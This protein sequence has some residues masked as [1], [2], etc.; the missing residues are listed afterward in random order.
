MIDNV[1]RAY[2]GF[3]VVAE[4][5]SATLASLPFTGESTRSFSSI[6]WAVCRLLHAL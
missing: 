3:V 5:C 6:N 1:D 4:G 2:S